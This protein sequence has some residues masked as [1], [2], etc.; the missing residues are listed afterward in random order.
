MKRTTHLLLLLLCLPFFQFAQNTIVRDGREFFNGEECQLYAYLNNNYSALHPIEGIWQFT[1][2]EYDAAGNETSRT[3]NEFKS[4]IIRDKGNYKRAFI[5]VNLDKS[6]CKPYQVVYSI[7]MA[8][9]NNSLFPCLPV[10]CTSNNTNYQY[11]ETNH[12]IYREAFSP[13]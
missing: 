12:I 13:L 3:P 2:I 9:G 1:R 11:D 7:Q 4:A 5:E 10:G 6:L 8:A